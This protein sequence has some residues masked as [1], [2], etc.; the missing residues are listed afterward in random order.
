WHGRSPARRRSHRQGPPGQ[1]GSR[2][3]G[4]PGGRRPVRR[5]PAGTPP[6]RCPADPGWDPAPASTPAWPRRVSWC[7]LNPK[8]DLV[9]IGPQL[10]CIHR[11]GWRGGG[12]ESAGDL[13]PEPV[14][15]AVLAPGD[16]PRE[17]GH[18]LVAEFDIG[19]QVVAVVAA[20]D[21]DR[22]EPGRLEVLE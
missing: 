15:D 12:V 11:R 17:E 22:L 7:L 10:G 9:R 5:R 2:A 16:G 18:A 19:A 14:G 21:L 6:T 8:P 1:P 13:G 3:C 20:P 4:R